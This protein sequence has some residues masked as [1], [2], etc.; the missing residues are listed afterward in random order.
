MQSKAHPSWTVLQWQTL[1]KRIC[2]KSN[3]K[4]PDEAS[5]SLSEFETTY[6]FHDQSFPR[7]QSNK[8]FY[9]KNQLWV[10]KLLPSASFPWSSPCQHHAFLHHHICI[11]SL[12]CFAIMLSTTPHA[13]AMTIVLCI[14]ITWTHCILS[15][16]HSIIQHP[17]TSTCPLNLTSSCSHIKSLSCLICYPALYFA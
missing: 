7:K 17:Q 14:I 8:P 2:C 16:L 13:Y 3:H 10:P 9:H 5:L 11:T 12:A 1:I 4:N 6:W 15:M